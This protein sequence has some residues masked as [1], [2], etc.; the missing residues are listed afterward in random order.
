MSAGA[1]DL[2]VLADWAEL[3][4][5]RLMGALR[6]QVVRG[7]EVLSFE[8]ATE[9]LK[10]GAARVL[11]P[12]LRL[13]AGRQYPPAGFSN[14]G[15]FADASPDRW[16]RVLL[17]RREA[18]RAKEGGRKPRTLAE[19]D[20]LLGVFDGHR[21]GALRFREPGGPFLDDDVAFAS[22][23]WTSLRELERA[24]RAL[25][26]DDAEADPS[27][28]K[29]LR[30]LVAP[31][32]SLGGARPKASVVDDAGKLW[33]AKFPSERDTRDV[34]A[35]E[36][37]AH[38]LAHRA[39]IEV[40]ESRLE[41]FGRRH[42]TFLSRRFDRTDQGARR[43]FASAMTLLQRRDGEEGASYLEL[44][45][46]IIRQGREV[47]ASLEQLWRR[48]A[49]SVCSSNADDHLRNHG[50]LLQGDARGGWRLAPAYDLNPV[51]GATGLSLNITEH[52]NALELELVLGL[53]VHCRLKPARARAVLGEVRAAVRQWR[54]EATA[55]GLSRG[56]QDA[57]ASAFE[58]A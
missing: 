15:A 26:R 54:R 28:A 52:D 45:S 34:G 16:G 10:S 7:K 39:G 38:R 4:G 51:P 25:E 50:F 18:Q 55:L 32:R 47:N 12:S 36:A 5:P 9:W 21:L 40:P 37:V 17:Q 22:P 23:P 48:V 14:F 1:R 44:V 2:E 43:H 24:S 35:W 42:R 41:Q 30:L 19:S 3:G 46:E 58:R 8:F 53:A 31:G 27:Y 11:D 6:V 56:E 13:V 29:W 20:F 33:I 49:F 57:M